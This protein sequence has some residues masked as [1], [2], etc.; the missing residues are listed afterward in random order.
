MLDA[1]AFTQDSHAGNQSDRVVWCGSVNT[2]RMHIDN[3]PRLLRREGQERIQG[4]CGLGNCLPRMVDRTVREG[5][6]CVAGNV[7][8]EIRR[9][10]IRV[11]GNLTS[12]KHGNSR[13]NHVVVASDHFGHAIPLCSSLVLGLPITAEGPC[14]AKHHAG[15]EDRVVKDFELHAKVVDDIR[16]GAYLPSRESGCGAATVIVGSAKHLHVVFLRDP[17]GDG[18]TQFPIDA[19]Q[20]I[21]ERQQI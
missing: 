13:D 9:I 15:L 5:D 10:R 19:T 16:L 21:P 3:V 2:V 6:W 20:G 12:L 4:R 7:F 14:R 1:I 8:E 18:N 11:D 17:T